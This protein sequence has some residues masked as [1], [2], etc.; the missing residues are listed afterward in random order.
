VDASGGDDESEIFNSVCME[1]TL[2]YFGVK[3]SFAQ[4]LEHAMNMVMMLL[5]GVREDEDILEIQDD[6]EINHVF[7]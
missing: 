5:E 1:G 4:A 7:K 3:V 6:K 2:Q